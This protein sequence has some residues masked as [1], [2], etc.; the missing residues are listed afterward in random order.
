MTRLLAHP[1]ARGLDENHPGTSDV[2]RRIVLSKPFLRRIYLEWYGKLLERLPGIEGEVLELGSG[3]GFF[4]EVLPSAITSE[5]FLCGGIRAVLDAR[6]L[7]FR[8]GALRAIVM[9]DVLHH[10]PDV[11][12]FFAEAVRTLAPGG[13]LLMVEPWVTPW[14]TWVYQ[15]FHPEPFRPDAEDWSF[16]SSGPLSGANGAIP[17]IVFRRDA[18]RFRER[19]PEFGIQ[20]IEP[21]MPFRYLLSGGVSLR[22]LSPGWSFSLWRGAE[23][24]LKPVMGS[25]AMFA[26]IQVERR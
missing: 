17:W 9:T 13:R 6:A 8:S 25:C 14:S 15:R 4:G 26:L 24:A 5:V 22:A 12:R 19:F 7:P 20:A 2:R 18:A 21:F 10:V 23:A 1:L 11:G 16:P 3:A